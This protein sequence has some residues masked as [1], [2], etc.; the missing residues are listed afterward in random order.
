MKRID[1]RLEKLEA[2]ASAARP[3]RVEWIVEGEMVTLVVNGQPE[4]SWF[5]C[6]PLDWDGGNDGSQFGNE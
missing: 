2:Q 3:D 4:K 1:S 6:S 5:G